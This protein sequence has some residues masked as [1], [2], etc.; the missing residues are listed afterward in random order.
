MIGMVMGD[1]NA[2]QRQ[3][4]ALKHFEHRARIAGIN[5]GG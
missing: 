3:A 4:L 2:G 1:E 5:H